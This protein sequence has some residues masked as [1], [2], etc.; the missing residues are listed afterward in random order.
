MCFHP[1]LAGEPNSTLECV[2]LAPLFLRPS[3][4]GTLARALGK[5]SNWQGGC[6][7]SV[8]FLNIVNMSALVSYT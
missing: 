8:E 3:R 6:Q 4:R 7:A 1:A 2:E 5:R